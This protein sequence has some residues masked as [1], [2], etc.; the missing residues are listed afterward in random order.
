MGA[1]LTRRTVTL[2]PGEY[3]VKGQPVRRQVAGLLI[4]L[5]ACLV[6][7]GWLAGRQSPPPGVGAADDVPGAWETVRPPLAEAA[8]P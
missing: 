8:R 5:V 4:A 3:R 7:L 1:G 6:G 2:H